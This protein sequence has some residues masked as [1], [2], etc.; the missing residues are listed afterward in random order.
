MIFKTVCA[1]CGAFMY[2]R[3]CTASEHCKALSIDGKILSHGICSKCK[4]AVAEKYKFKLNRRKKHG[5]V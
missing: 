3:N 4:M 5:L 1:W 2:E